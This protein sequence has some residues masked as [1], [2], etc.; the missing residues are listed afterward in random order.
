MLRSRISTVESPFAFQEQEPYNTNRLR[1]TAAS[2]IRTARSIESAFLRSV[3]YSSRKMLP[4]SQKALPLG[5][6][7]S[8]GN[9]V[10]TANDVQWSGGDGLYPSSS[11][12]RSSGAHACNT[13][14]VSRCR[15]D[16]A[17]CFWSDC[18]E[19]PL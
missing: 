19:Q 16:F 15:N 18:Y 14:S 2:S 7:P 8:G 12:L 17:D 10:L 4:S 1:L 5:R 9:N 13:E 11:L 3:I 6:L